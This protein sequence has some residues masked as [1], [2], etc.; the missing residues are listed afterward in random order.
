MLSVT[1]NLVP[2]SVSRTQARLVGSESLGEKLRNEGSLAWINSGYVV[3]GP[4]I[5]SFI[6]PPKWLGHGAKLGIHLWPRSQHVIHLLS[7][8][9]EKK[10][11]K[12]KERGGENKEVM[13]DGTACD[14]GAASILSSFLSA[15]CGPGSGQR[16]HREL[17][18][19][20]AA[21]LPRN[22]LIWKCLWTLALYP[23]SILR[24]YQI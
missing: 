18:K 3:W 23:Q 16:I 17:V 11:R 7:Q 2:Y 20:F 14:R 19:Q 13:G 1:Y 21:Q 12:E 5:Y 6:G 24:I 15:G 22:P 4:R 8:R 10:V 9:A